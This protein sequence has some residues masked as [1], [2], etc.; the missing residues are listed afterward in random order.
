MADFRGVEKRQEAYADIYTGS[1]EQLLAAGLVSEHQFPP[2]GSRR[3]WVTYCDGELIQKSRYRMDERYLRVQNWDVQNGVYRVWIGL[4]SAVQKQRRAAERRQV[5]AWRA[6]RV[7]ARCHVAPR[8]GGDVQ[9]RRSAQ[10][11][12]LFPRLRAAR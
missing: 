8:P 4:A 12:P 2:R 6:T 11:I 9:P 7:G 10:V 3:G 5:E 1:R